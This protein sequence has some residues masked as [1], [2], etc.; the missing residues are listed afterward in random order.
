M[1]GLQKIPGGD[2]RFYNNI[3][4]GDSGLAPY[5]KAAQPVQ[6]AGNVFLKGAKPSNA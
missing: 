4:V 2:D 5:D 3:F 6:M 1:A